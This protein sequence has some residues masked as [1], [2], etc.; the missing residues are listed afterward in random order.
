M[1]SA[2]SASNRKDNHSD[3][4]KSDEALRS[5]YPFATLLLKQDYIIEDAP[6]RR[7]YH[8]RFQGITTKSRSEGVALDC[9][10]KCAEKTHQC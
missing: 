5:T 4:R 10:V 1:Q 7:A 8:S 9:L 6:Q 2:D 3:S